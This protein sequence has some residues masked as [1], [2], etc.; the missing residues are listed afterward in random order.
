M[1]GVGPDRF[2]HQVKFIGAI[3]FARHT[4]GLA[5]HEVVGLGEVMQP[6]DT[7]GV[8]V[9]HQQHRARSVL[10]PREQE[11]MIGAEVKHGGEMGRG[12]API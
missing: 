2:N 5:R 6:I 9:K 1:L 10:L 12:L 4:I 3:D 8:A 11:E 7:L